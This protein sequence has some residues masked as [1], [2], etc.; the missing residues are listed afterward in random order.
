LAVGPASAHHGYAQYDRCKSVM[1]EG[2]VTSV[3]WAN[4]HIVIDLK[5][6]DVGDYRVEWFSLTNLEQAAIGAKLNAGEH[7]VV[8]GSVMRDPA[9]KVMSLV[10]EIRRPSDG[11]G[12]TR[13]PRPAPTGCQAA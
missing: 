11:W 8:T 1:L 3:L 13:A 6:K 2:E 10:S 4:P 12:W 5:T 9:L 7:V